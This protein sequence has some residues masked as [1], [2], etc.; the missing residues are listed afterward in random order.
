MRIDGG[1]IVEA[2]FAMCVDTESGLVH[3]GQLDPGDREPGQIL[4]E[5]FVDY[6]E[7]TCAGNCPNQIEVNDP[8]LAEYLRD[9]LLAIGIEVRLVDRLAALAPALRSLFDYMGAQTVEPPS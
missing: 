4:L 2:R 8:E 5:A 3:P 7:Q 6:V 9:Q 1:E